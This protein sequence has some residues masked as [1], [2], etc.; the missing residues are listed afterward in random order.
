MSVIAEA[1]EKGLGRRAKSGGFGSGCRVVVVG[2]GPY[3]LAVGAHLKSAGI[4]TRVF[5]EPLGFWR[6]NMPKGMRLRSPWK[7]SHI[8]DPA[9][10][11]TLDMYVASGRMKR[12]E[13]VPLDEFVQYGEWFQQNNVPDVDRRQVA[14]MDAAPGGFR[15]VL[16]D[17]EKI[18]ARRVV[19]ATGLANQAYYPPEFEGFPQELVSHSV[20][21]PDLGIFRG[22]RIAVIGRGQ[23]A[24]ESAVLL[25][26]NGAEVELISRGPVHWI[27]S[28][29]PGETKWKLHQAITPPSPVGPFPLNWLNEMP[30]IMHR[31]SRNLRQKIAIRSLRPA[32]SAWLMPRSKEVR[33]TP[34][35]TVASVKALD[36]RLILKLDDGS[37]STVDHVLLATGYKIDIAKPGILSPELVNM[38]ERIDGYPVLRGNFESSVA[39]L[40]FMGCN[41]VPS[42]G[43]LMRFIWGAGYAARSVT[44]GVLSEKL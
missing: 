40:H 43:P 30:G 42:Y 37:Q 34:G 6:R 27:G 4:E 20:D 31:V 18:N 10:R 32:A 15:L 23:S 16:K 39:G 36:S 33:M 14:R 25:S 2:A 8:S 11:F 13:P 41:A 7:G 3:G 44:R 29:V 1:P 24:L 17:G 5:G 19:M 9:G 26:E 12:S 21:H 28:E 35:R 38:V 22:R